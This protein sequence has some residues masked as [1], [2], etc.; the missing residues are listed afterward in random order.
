MSQ[1]KSWKLNEFTPFI[2]GKVLVQKMKQLKTEMKQHCTCQANFITV[3]GMF[4]NKLGL[5]AY[6]QLTN[7]FICAVSPTLNFAASYSSVQFYTLQQIS[8]CSADEAA[9][10]SYFL[11]CQYD[12]I[13][14]G[15]LKCITV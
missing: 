14:V 2:P 5:L 12:T 6:I 3:Y 11:S 13:A 15:K 7:T 1:K 9:L 4:S 8:F 10:E